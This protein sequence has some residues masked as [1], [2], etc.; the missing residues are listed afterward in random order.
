MKIV[1]IGAGKVGYTLAEQLSNEAHQLRILDIDPNATEYLEKNLD[2]LVFEGDGLDVNSLRELEVATAD[3]VIATM[4]T[5]EQNLTACLLAKKLGAKNTVARV[6]EPKHLETA[7]LLRNDLGLSMILNP[8]AASAAEIARILRT[9]SAIKIDTFCKGKVELYKVRLAADSPLCG[10]SLQALGRQHKGILICTVER[11]EQVHI[12]GGSFVL[13]AG[14]YIN[15]VANPTSAYRF[16]KKIKIPVHPVQ[17]VMII[18]GSLIAYYLAKELGKFNTN[19]KIIDTNKDVCDRLAVDLNS[20]SII[21]GDGTDENLLM[22]EHIDQMDAVVT[23]TGY[24]EANVLISL[25][26]RTV[27]EAKIVTKINRNG[28]TRI[29]SAMELGSVFHPRDIAANLTVRF[30]RALNNSSGSNVETLYKLMGGRVEALEFRVT[31]KFR[32]CGVK[33]MDLKTR[34]NLL[35]GAIYRNGE[36][37]TPGGQDSILPGDGVV[38]VTT[39]MGLKELD[40]I[41]E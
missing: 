40:D 32:G 37:I 16:L 38:V 22:A 4:S 2:V 29:I 20:A 3:L 35:I 15:F 31:E 11:A 39:N 23:L 30:T 17:Q 7:N 19:V 34:R 26:A 12:P 5:D 1:I 28:F 27:S 8:E 24:D 36:I 6:R 33:L 21:H 14:D 13:Q 9:P 25:H 41:L 10:L 18:G